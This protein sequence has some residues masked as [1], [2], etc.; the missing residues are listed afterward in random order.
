MDLPKSPAKNGDQ[1]CNFL[2]IGEGADEDWVVP[3]ELKKGK[4]SDSNI[5]SQLKAG[6]RVAQ[7]VIPNNASFR[8]RPVAAYGGT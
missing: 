4:A 5:V 7:Q 1:R 6:A 2:F 3:M 8:F